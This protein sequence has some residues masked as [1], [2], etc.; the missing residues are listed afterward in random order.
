M[1]ALGAGMGVCNIVGAR[2]GAR[3]ALRRGAGFVRVVLLIVV[4]AM[5]AKMGYDQFG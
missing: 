3:L 5:V 4:A 2:I 1:W